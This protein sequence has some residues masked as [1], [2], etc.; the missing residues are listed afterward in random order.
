MIFLL[1]IFSGLVPKYEL[2]CENNSVV[3]QA[4]R[5]E[6]Q[7]YVP[8]KPVAELLNINYVLDNTTQRLYLTNK[9]HK[10]VLIADIG[11]LSCDSLYKNLPFAPRFIVGEVYFPLLEI[12]P[13]LGGTFGKLIFIKK[14]EEVPIISKITLFTRADST[15]LKYEW[16]RPLEFDVQF[17]PKK[18]I[19]EIDGQYKLKP[20]LIPTGEIKSVNLLPYK[21]YTRLEL[22]LGNINSFLER[23]DEVVFYN[24]ITSKVSL[25]VID[26]GH[27]GIDPGAVGK[28]GLYEKDATLD[29][30]SMLKDLIEDSLGIKVF[31]TRDKDK[32]LSLKGRTD[33]AN[34]HSAD[35]FISIHCNASPKSRKVRGFETYFL[36]EAKTTEARAVAAL[37]NASLKFDGVEPTDEISFILYDLAQSAFLEES[38]CLAEFIQTGAEELL[39]IPALGISQAG[40]YVLRGA[41]MPAVLVETAFI[42]NLEEENLLRE[43][44][45]KKKLAYCIFNGTKNFVEDYER[46]LN[47]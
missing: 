19:I 9:D 30:A 26:P 47:N 24:K 7:D 45:F 29:I 13:I 43:K 34:S 5:I 3:I 15:I 32:Y 40:F 22:E 11:V 25:I 46:R 1:T 17:L 6:F 8:L 4:E 41:F 27:G 38:N 36:S 23:E 2:V 31:L 10:L 37:E 44:S 39:S 12:I 18:V 21:T 42:S 16:E 33:F 28:K 14:L 35:L 20:K